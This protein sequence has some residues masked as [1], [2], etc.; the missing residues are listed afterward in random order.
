M[1]VRCL[2]AGLLFALVE[3]ALAQQ[4]VPRPTYYATAAG[5]TSGATK[6]YLSIFNSSGSSVSV[7]IVRIWASVDSQ[8]AVTGLQPGFTISR[9]TT[10]GAT[11]T[12][13]TPALADTTNAA[14]PAN[15]T[16]KTNCT[17]DPTGLTTLFRSSIYA[18]ETQRGTLT[19]YEKHPNAQPL[20]L[21]PAQGVTV[22]SGGTAP[23]GVLSLT[24]EF[25]T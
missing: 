19:L 1:W 24:I 10:D 12:S 23:V 2:V 9:Y 25:T 8:A 18:D 20:T 16:A 14:L 4:P 3:P 22:I 11:C 7:R 6:D 21:A 13:I 15:V 5:V 17:T